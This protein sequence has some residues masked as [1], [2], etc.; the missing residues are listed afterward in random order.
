VKKLIGWL[1]MVTLLPAAFIA[2]CGDKSTPSSPGAP[3]STATPTNTSTRT[4]TQTTTITWTRTRTSTPT[5]TP[6]GTRTPTVTPTVQ[7]A[8]DLGSAA[9]Y[10][11]LTYAEVT[12]SGATTLCGNLGLHPGS[13][14]DGGIV[15]I[16]GGVKNVANGAALTAKTDLSTAY[17][18]IAGRSGGVLLPGGTDIGGL[19]LY[20]GLYTCDGNLS[21]SSADLTLDA[22]SNPNAIFIFQVSGILDVT[23]GRQVFL[24]TG[25]QSKNVFWQVTDYCSLGTTVHF[26][27]TILAYNSVTLNTLATLNGRAFGENGNVTLLSNTITDPTP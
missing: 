22:L 12:N 13:S 5:D 19:T 11:V 6:V 18:N 14:V 23:S 9:S 21:I 25:A 17:T 8:V 20:P 24:N 26:V 1:I 15:N 16:C 7:A 27:G 10:A 3:G 2:G 4:I